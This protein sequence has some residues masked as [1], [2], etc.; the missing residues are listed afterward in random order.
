MRATPKTSSPCSEVNTRSSARGAVDLPR[1]P[2]V[3]AV[4]MLAAANFELFEDSYLDVLLR[5]AL[6]LLLGRHVC[7]VLIVDWSF[8]DVVKR[9]ATFGDFGLWAA[10]TFIRA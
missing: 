5:A 6:N 10:R 7:C 1:G 4:K 3:Q 8:V 9:G 2:G